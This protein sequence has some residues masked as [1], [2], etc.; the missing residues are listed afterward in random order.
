MFR[1]LWAL[2]IKIPPPLF[3]RFLPLM[4][5]MGLSF[6]SGMYVF[7][8]LIVRRD[9]LLPCAI[10]GA[11]FGLYMAAY[12]RSK[13]KSLKLPSEWKDY[14]LDRQRKSN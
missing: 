3:I 2:G 12:F 9:V 5:L 14:G 6:G 11:L 8:W 10:G 1:H 4:F 7:M 13:A